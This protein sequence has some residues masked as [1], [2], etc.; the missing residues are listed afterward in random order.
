[1]CDEYW[2]SVLCFPTLQCPMLQDD[3]CMHF[4]LYQ[5][6]HTQNLRLTMLTRHPSQIKCLD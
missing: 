2:H 1:M 6:Q 3:S 4:D 5:H